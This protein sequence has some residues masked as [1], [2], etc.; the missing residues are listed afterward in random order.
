MHRTV[1]PWKRCSRP[2]ER[3]T[4]AQREQTRLVTQLGVRRPGGGGRTGAPRCRDKCRV[5]TRNRDVCAQALGESPPVAPSKQFTRGQGAPSDVA[6]PERPARRILEP[7]LTHA[8]AADRHVYGGRQWRPRKRTRQGPIKPRRPELRR[9]CALI[10][11]RPAVIERLCCQLRNGPLRQEGHARGPYGPVELKRRGEE[12]GRGWT[13]AAC[14][15]NG[16][17]AP[18]AVLES[19]PRGTSFHVEHS[20]VQEPPVRNGPESLAP[21][22]RDE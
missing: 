22:P 14:G 11:A 20:G 15:S 16:E 5:T 18:R 19:V 6:R 17:P 1:P 7:I 8:F 2:A 12:R 10:F 9:K 4:N 3:A 21:R 13:H